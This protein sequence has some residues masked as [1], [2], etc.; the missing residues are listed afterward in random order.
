MTEHLERARIARAI[1]LH[2]MQRLAP[3]DACGHATGQ[4]AGHAADLHI[5]R[6]NSVIR[7]VKET[8][9]MLGSGLLQGQ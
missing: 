1:K 3:A 9:W 6:R 7:P 5:S 8:G 4:R 2:L